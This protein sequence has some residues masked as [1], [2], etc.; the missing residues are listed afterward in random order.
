MQRGRTL[1]VTCVLCL[2]AAA[3][4]Q[5]PPGAPSA[6]ATAAGPAPVAADAPPTPSPPPPPPPASPVPEGRHSRHSFEVAYLGHNFIHPGLQ[7]GYSFRPLQSPARL[8]A[9]VLGIDAGAY[10]WL[11][12]DI[13]ALVLPRIGW[14]GRHRVGLQG[15]ASFHLGYLQS[16]LAS[17][18]YQV[19]AGQVVEAS[20]AGIANLLFGVTAG[21]G[22]FI[23]RAG[24]TPF[25]RAGVL[26]HTPVFDQLL[27]RFVLNLGVEVRL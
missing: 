21:V 8:H 2:P 14:R 18:A 19:E 24:V 26:W 13:G 9:L 17:P 20:R 12:H 27:L 16:L 7:V 5:E 4:G 10:A 23:P 11:R 3:R 22:W 6:E 25:A 1:L 15:E